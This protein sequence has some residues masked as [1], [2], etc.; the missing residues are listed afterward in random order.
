V[1]KHNGGATYTVVL[2]LQHFSNTEAVQTAGQMLRHSGARLASD[3]DDVSPELPAPQLNPSRAGS[4][5]AS[6]AV[7]GRLADRTQ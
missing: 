3:C 5:Q 4:L 1:V 7:K 2:G 6:P